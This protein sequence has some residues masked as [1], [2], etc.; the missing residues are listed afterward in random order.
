ME[1]QQLVYGYNNG[2]SLL[3]GSIDLPVED[4]SLLLE[5]TDWS[6]VNESITPTYITGFPLVKSNFYVFMRTW[7][8]E[9]M[10]R[11][12][13]VWSHVLLIQR[14]DFT[15]L[16]NIEALIDL[17]LRPSLIKNSLEAY[18]KTIIIDNKVIDNHVNTLKSE[19]HESFIKKLIFNL[20]S[21]NDP[22][23]LAPN[24]NIKSFELLFLKL[25]WAQPINDRFLFSFCT[26]TSTPRKYLNKEFRLQI[27]SKESFRLKTDEEDNYE[28]WVNIIYKEINFSSINYIKYL[29]NISDDI[30]PNQQKSIAL[31]QIY[32][33]ISNGVLKYDSKT[34]VTCL[35]DSLAI[36][37][38]DKTEARKL[39]RGLLSKNILVS[40]KEEDFFLQ[41]M[42]ITENYSSF[43][44]DDLLIID[45]V[46]ELYNSDRKHFF[47][48][49]SNTIKENINEYG[50]SI[51][52]KS[53]ILVTENDIETLI[54]DYWPLFTIFVNIRPSIITLNK[55][56]AINESK[57]QD[58]INI[59]LSN[60]KSV[61]IDWQ[62]VLNII[63]DSNIFLLPNTIATIKKVEP[64]FISIILNW[65]DSNPQ[66]E[67]YQQWI[68]ELSNNPDE[69]L[70]WI[71]LKN[72]INFSTM[73]LI[74]RII[75]PNSRI[76]IRRGT[77]L[78]M[79]FSMSAA[80]NKIKESIYIHAFL[81][82]LAFNFNDSNAFKLLKNSFFIIYNEIADDTL[83]YK[84]ASMVLEHTKPTFWQDWDKC[85]K[86]RNALADKFNEA[87]WD[88]SL[89]IDIVRKESLADEIWILCKKRK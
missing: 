7:Y 49:L 1:I 40:L 61:D 22:V 78:W 6:G 64:T 34:F 19:V 27:V 66:S 88:T 89:I 17:L 48:L 74:V 79:P 82:S 2:H 53:S 32:D 70:N 73:I 63:L 37:F 26:G 46:I 18:N 8:A 81:T 62:F 28:S 36:Y 77:G 72:R 10:P 84:L 58:I 30:N 14:Q 5:L 21:T 3:N 51:F 24:P 16:T 43:D 33:L 87:R 45:R 75:N 20:Y 76:V 44:F 54:D 55:S 9:E 56:W 41:K 59:I 50:I 13:C 23:Y 80:S 29:N 35:L 4:K 71:E 47:E 12:G 60:E 15:N 65:Y 83:D 25:W 86:L 11:P 68:S 38:P 31:S 57:C 69:I 39:K 67:L 85:K 52:E 42:L